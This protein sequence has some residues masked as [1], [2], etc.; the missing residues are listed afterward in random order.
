MII[1]WRIG[2]VKS[3]T[4]IGWE[5]LLPDSDQRLGD[6][7]LLSSMGLIFSSIEGVNCWNIGELNSRNNHTFDFEY[8]L[9]QSWKL[10]ES[11]GKSYLSIIRLAKRWFIRPLDLPI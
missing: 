10:L 11:Q 6:Y 4:F 9:L 8:T 3:K 1:G 7:C 5:V 2:D